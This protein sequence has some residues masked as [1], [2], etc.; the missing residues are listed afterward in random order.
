V[1]QSTVSRTIRGRSIHCLLLRREDLLSIPWYL[2]V[3]TDNPFTLLVSLV[4]LPESSVNR[5][6]SQVWSVIGRFKPLRFAK[7][8]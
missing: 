5:T 8:R 3:R 1:P 2:W 4:L 7:V 6:Q